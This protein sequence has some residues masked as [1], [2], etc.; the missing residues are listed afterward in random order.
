MIVD[1]CE[2]ADFNQSQVAAEIGVQP[3]AITRLVKGEQQ[4][5]LHGSG[6]KLE[7]LYERYRHSIL[8]AKRKK[9]RELMAE[10][11][12]AGAP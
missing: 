5:L 4:D 3:S 11:K 8:D 1:L 10:V 6:K 9:A 7:E 12:A 2:F